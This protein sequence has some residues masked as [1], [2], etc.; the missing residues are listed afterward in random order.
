MSKTLKEISE[1][2]IKL[3]YKEVIAP[4]EQGLPEEVQNLI[5]NIVY[6]RENENNDF[7]F[8]LYL[9]KN[10]LKAVIFG[11]PKTVTTFLKEK[12]DFFNLKENNLKELK[13]E[14]TD[15]N[16][17][18]NNVTISEQANYNEINI[19]SFHQLFI[20]KDYNLQIIFSSGNN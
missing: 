5:P 1:K 12:E 4:L 2:F 14:I 16:F 18:K 20:E 9:K 15:S 13:S 17:I 7:E 8:W 10:I 19:D 6:Y 3:G 11:K